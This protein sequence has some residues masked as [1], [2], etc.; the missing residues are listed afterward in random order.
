MGVLYKGTQRISPV[1]TK[2]QKYCLVKQNSNHTLVNSPELIDMT[3]ITNLGP[4]VLAYAYYQNAPTILN[5]SNLTALSGTYCCYNVCTSSSGLQTIDFSNVTN[6]SGSYALS[7]AFNGCQNLQ[8]AYF[9]SLTTISGSYAFYCVFNYCTKLTNV[10]FTGL[11]TIS[12]SNVFDRAFYNCNLLTSVDFSNLVTVS[13]SYVFQYAFSGCSHLEKLDFS[14]LKTLGNYGFYYMCQNLTSL[15]KVDFGNLESV[16]TY[17]FSYAFMG[18]TGITNTIDLSTIKTV[19]NYGFYYAF[20]N[21]TNM[22][23]EIDLSNLETVGI[24]SFQY[25]F[26]NCKNITSVTFGDTTPYN[27]YSYYCA[28]TKCTNITSVDLSG[29][30]TVSS[31]YAFYLAF[32]NCTGITNI[33]L[34]NLT[35][36]TAENGCYGLFRI[37]DDITEISPITS[38][39]VPSLTTVSASGGFDNVFRGNKSLQSVRIPNLK[40]AIGG[41]TLIRSLVIYCNSLTELD[42]SSLTELNATNGYG[43]SYFASSTALS[44]F[45]FTSLDT[46]IG[47]DNFHYAFQNC[48]NLTTLSFPALHNISNNTFNSNNTLSGCS[49]VTVHFPSNLQSTI[50]SWAAIIGGFGGTNTTVLFDLPSTKYLT[51]ADSNTYKRNPKYDTTTALAWRIG[52]D[53]TPTYYTSGIIDPQ[54]GDTIYSD[55]TCTTAVTTISSIEA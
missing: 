35:S 23:G 36:I 50:G 31:P 45:E 55:A 5:F 52:M 49:N 30:T 43:A 13:G 40:S 27:N 7:N 42:L 19:G 6:I 15:Q 54:V 10:D 18:C 20:N 16:G 3:D 4:Y 39:N 48:T 29:I 12:G 38:V 26:Q 11:T 28:F 33:N 51:G 21:C 17:G 41:T 25:A 47:Q 8:N 9:N 14:N 46:T 37:D 53:L 2:K 32:S 1:I 24:Y 44:S 22:A 34:D